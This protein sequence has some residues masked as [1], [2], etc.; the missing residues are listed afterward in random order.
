[1]N[2]R[3]VPTSLF[4][5]GKYRRLAVKDTQQDAAFFDSANPDNKGKRDQIAMLALDELLDW[6][7]EF[8]IS[9]V[10]HS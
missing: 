2:W 8:G 6:L 5:V 4:N 7:S 3:G 1:M 10:Y 9:A